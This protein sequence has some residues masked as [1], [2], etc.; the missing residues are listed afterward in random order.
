MDYR[1]SRFKRP[2]GYISIDKI[3]I[4]AFVVKES[5]MNVVSSVNDLQMV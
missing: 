3:G 2:R 4:F 1:A 5:Q